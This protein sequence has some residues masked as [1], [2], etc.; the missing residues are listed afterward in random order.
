MV[1]ILLTGGSGF[2]GKN[3]LNYFQNDTRISID[4]PGSRELD[5]LDEKMVFNTL[6]KEQ[7]DVV[8]NFAGYSPV[9]SVK[10]KDANKIL[11]YNLRMYYNFEKNSSLF[12]KMFCIGSGAEYDKRFDIIS[13]KEDDIGKKIPIDQY[14]MEKYTI[15]RLIEQ[16]DNIYNLRIFGLF[17]PYEFW[18]RRFISNMCF[19]ALTNQPFEINQNVY[20]D[21][22]WIYDFIRILERFILLDD[23]KFHTINI[24]SGEKTDLFQLADIVKKIS[25]SEEKIVFL[26][27]GMGKEYTCCNSRLMELFPDFDFTSKN[28]AI[29]KL[30]EWYRKDSKKIFG[31][32]I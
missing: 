26:N 4:A 9:G 10:E 25:G 13:V 27:E 23:I 21:Y 8:L 32:V 31:E 12:G 28:E 17:G 7:Y 14:G 6:R 19:R 16:S 29:R 3:V 22:V 15:G 11:E 24:G 2:V 20:F 30:Y 1:K 18:Q 5:C